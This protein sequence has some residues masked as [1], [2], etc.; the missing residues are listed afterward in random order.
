MSAAADE[1]LVWSR[2]STLA[3]AA[4]RQCVLEV[5]G[6]DRLSWLNG[7]LTC[8]L[9][10]RGEG[11][12]VQGLALAQKGKIVSDVVAVVAKER[13]LLIVQRR[14][15]DGLVASF[16]H[17]LMMEDAEL[18]RGSDIPWFLHG[19]L[20]ALP[21]VRRAERAASL[22]SRARAARWS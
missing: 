17:H 5:T 18:H 20:A 16:E 4:P 6:T 21:R 11:D 10:K 19:P 15:V 12:V 22:T 9:S 1:Q 13:V 14:T 3:L 8:D 7:L 2:T